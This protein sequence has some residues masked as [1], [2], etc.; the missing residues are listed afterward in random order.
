MINW[1]FQLSDDNKIKFLGLIGAVIGFSVALWQYTVSQKWKKAEFLASEYKNFISNDYVQKAFA[2][3]DGFKINVPY[4]DTSGSAKFICF[5]K[6]KLKTALTNIHTDKAKNRFYAEDPEST[7]I[8][9]CIDKFLFKL[10]V[11]Q[12]HIDSKLIKP[13]MLEPYV[14]YWLDLLTN[15]TDDTIDN[16][17]KGLIHQYIKD[18]KIVSLIKLFNTFKKPI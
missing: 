10:G 13:E 12:V 17:S 11:M 1:F 14:I 2:M 16:D 4:T 6:T 9:L 18:N 5:D 8:R 15:K 7:Y 3:L